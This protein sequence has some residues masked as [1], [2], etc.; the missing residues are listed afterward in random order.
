MKILG[1]EAASDERR[2]SVAEKVNNWRCVGRLRIVRRAS[3]RLARGQPW[4]SSG[5]GKQGQVSSGVVGVG[6]VPPAQVRLEGEQRQKLLSKTRPKSGQAATIGPRSP[7]TIL[8]KAFGALAVAAESDVQM[9]GVT[10]SSSQA[11]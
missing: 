11:P 1:K 5:A 10:P 7:G 4:E 9:P 3:H 6:F 8:Q 2:L